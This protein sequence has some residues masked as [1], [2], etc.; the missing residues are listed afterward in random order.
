MSI[1]FFGRKMFSSVFLFCFFLYC[2]FII[3]TR[4]TYILFCFVV[5]HHSLFSQFVLFAAYALSHSL[6]EEGLRIY[7]G[8]PR[9]SLERIVQ[10]PLDR[11]PPRFQNDVLPDV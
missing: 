6:P 10:K 7:A 8:N 3:T 2:F 4:E 1:V 5:E 11:A 9:N